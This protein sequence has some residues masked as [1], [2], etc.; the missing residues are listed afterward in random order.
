MVDESLEKIS[1]Q[2]G[3]PKKNNKIIFINFGGRKEKNYFFCSYFRHIS[4][5]VYSNFDWESSLDAE[6]DSASNEYPQCILLTDP[7]TPKTRN[8]R[9][10]VMMTS[11]SHFFRYFLFLGLWGP[12]KLCSVGTHWMRNQIPHPKSSPNRNLSKNTR[13]Y[14]E[15]TN[16]KSSF[17]L[18][19]SKINQYY[20]IILTI[21]LLFSLGGPF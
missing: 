2:N 5:C 10:N 18:S 12:S 13:R 4:L 8:T 7:A 20:F 3:P 9:K 19:S 14:V 1:T 11:S 6:F 17:F 15:N 16:T 21:I